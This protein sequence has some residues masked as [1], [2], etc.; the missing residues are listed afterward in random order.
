MSIGTGAPAR[1]DSSKNT[2]C[3]IGR[4]ALAAPLLRPADSGPAVGRHLLPDVLRHLADALA[5]AQVV[6]DLGREELVVVR[7]QLV[8]QRLVLLRQPDVH[9]GPLATG[10]SRTCSMFAVRAPSSC[11][12]AA[13]DRVDRRPAARTI[14]SDGA[15]L[16]RRSRAAGSGA[17]ASL[18]ALRRGRRGRVVGGRARRCCEDRPD[19]RRSRSARSTPSCTRGAPATPATMATL[20]DKPPADLATT[21]TSLVKSAPGST[22]TYTRDRRSCATSRRTDAT[23]TYHAQV[24]AR[25]ASARSSGTARCTLVHVKRRTDAVARSRWDPRTSTPG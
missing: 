15:H 12:C 23:A 22:A 8:A 7:A 14:R 17:C 11:N 21:A 3:S 24:D 20:L 13:P 9:T 2:N 18:I 6:L 16:Q 10:R 5:L 19:R 4:E 1:I 25:R